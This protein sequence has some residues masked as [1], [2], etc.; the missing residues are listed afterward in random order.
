[1]PVV[2]PD[3]LGSRW[4]SIWMPATPASMNSWTVRW[5]LI[6]APYPVSAS[7]IHGD[8]DAA[9]DAFGVRY[10]L[11]QGQPTGIGGAL[12][13]PCRHAAG[14]LERLES[15]VLRHLSVDRQRTERHDDGLRP[16]E[17]LTQRRTWRCRR[18]DEQPVA[19]L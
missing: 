18:H 9:G 10:H 15:C 7:Q 19:G 13:P 14:K 8:V 12:G 4:S 17:N 1:M 2:P 6:G 16:L 5:T 11:G 3:F